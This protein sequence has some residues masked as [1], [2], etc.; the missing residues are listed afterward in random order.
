M[1]TFEF[2]NSYKNEIDNK[3][4]DENCI[5]ALKIYDSCKVQDC[6]RTDVLGPARAAEN[7]TLGDEEI[8]KGEIIDPPSNAATVSIDKLRTKKIMIVGKEPS[9]FKKGYWDIS[10]RY[11]FVY[12]LTFRESNGSII[13]TVKANSIYNKKVCLFGSEGT[14]IVIASDLLTQSLGNVLEADPFV[15][16]EGKAVSLE[17]KLHF[18]KVKKCGCGNESSP[19]DYPPESNAVLVT[20]GL[21]TVIKVC[22]LVDMQ[23]ESRGMCEPKNC[24]CTGVTPCEFFD[25]IEFPMDVFAPPVK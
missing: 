23:V 5:V 22:R 14:D 21:F 7:T 9:P 3:I 11:V 1:G 24:E 10:I 2:E 6:C 16:V 19:E 13:G 20:I 18:A 12:T 8:I 4:M 15:I 25:G 17:A